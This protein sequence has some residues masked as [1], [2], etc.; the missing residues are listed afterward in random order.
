[1]A[2]INSSTGQVTINGAGTVSV[3]V[4]QAALGCFSATTASSTLT[5][6]KKTLSVVANNQSKTYNTAN[7]ILTISYTGFIGSDNAAGIDVPP[8]I[9]T[10][11]VL[12]SAVGTYPITAFGGLDNNYTFTFTGGTLTVNKATPT[13]S[14]TSTAAGQAGAT[15]SLTSTTNSTG[16]VTWT[17][18]SGNGSIS[19]STLTLLSAGSVTIQANLAADANYNAATAQQTVTISAQTVP[20]ITYANVNQTYG[21]APFP[22][23]ATSNSCRQC[24]CSH[25]SCHR[26]SDHLRRRDCKCTGEPSPKRYLRRW[27]PNGYL[28]HR[29]KSIGGN[30][31]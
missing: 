26:N 27:N 7:P 3:G 1:L 24:F 14:I 25:Q 20:T 6:A 21:A 30:G 19:G 12:N 4:S 17:V 29:Q 16:A 5:I 9:T 13:L 31:S 23:T 28:D 8:T 22:I 11:A 18:V 15:I 2:T 10:T